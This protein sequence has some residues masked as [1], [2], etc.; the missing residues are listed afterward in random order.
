MIINSV[1]LAICQSSPTGISRVELEEL[2]NL[3]RRQVEQALTDLLHQ[4]K[5]DS[6]RAGYPRHSSLYTVRLV[7]I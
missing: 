5:I 2:L 6:L 7:K 1:Y 4:K 3:S